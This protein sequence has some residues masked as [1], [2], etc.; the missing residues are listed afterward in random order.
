MRFR[1][2]KGIRLSYEKQGLIYFTCRTYREQPAKVQEKILTLCEKASRENPYAL[3]VLLTTD[4]S[5]TAIAMKFNISSEN[6]LYA[7]RRRFYE[8]WGRL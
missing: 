6:T 7:A 3:F 2:Y 4:Q 1:K 5:T 8:M